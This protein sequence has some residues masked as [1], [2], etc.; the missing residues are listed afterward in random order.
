MIESIKASPI[1][2]VSEVTTVRGLDRVLSHPNGFI[3]LVECLESRIEVGLMVS[4]S[5]TF[6]ERNP[7]K[8]LGEFRKDEI[9]EHEFLVGERNEV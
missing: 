2:S 8:N 9:G 4:A 3:K 6:F 1:A 5:E 7:L